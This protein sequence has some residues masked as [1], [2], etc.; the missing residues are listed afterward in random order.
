MKLWSPYSNLQRLHASITWDPPSQLILRESMFI[1][2]HFHRQ[3]HLG[4]ESQLPHGMMT[5]ATNFPHFLRR[6]ALHAIDRQQ[7]LR[8][9][10]F[11]L[12]TIRAP[13]QISPHHSTPYRVLSH[14]FPPSI[15][16]VLSVSTTSSLETP[17]LFVSP[18][19]GI[20]I[21]DLKCG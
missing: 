7:I 6:L 2:D 3:S 17:H 10:I 15:H 18:F 9:S 12:S 5:Y 21:V 4:N 14:P 19:A 16:L 20:A 8:T 13:R 11:S 1:S